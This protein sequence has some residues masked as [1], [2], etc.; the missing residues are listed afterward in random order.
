MRKV[1]LVLAGLGVAIGSAH[2]QTGDPPSLFTRQ[3]AIW[4][5]VFVIGSVGLSTADVRVARFVN[6]SAHRSEGRDRFA[7]NV[8][9]AQEGTL[10]IGNMALWGIARLA[11]LPAMAD[12][13]FHA[14]EAVVVGS[15]A[16]QVIRGPLGRS[17]PH[18]TNH[19]DQ[20]DFKP[21]RGFREFEHRAFPSIHTA[22]AFAVAT[23]YTLETQRRAPRATWIVAPVAY[24]LALGPALSRMYTG[25]HWASDILGG[26]IMGAFAGVK[27]VRYNH[28]VRPNNRVNRFF[29]GARNVQIG[30]GA[31]S[32]SASYATRF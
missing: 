18:V 25:Q 8:A 2:A 12:I 27:M 15:L 9:K 3:D 19:S 10:F 28:D 13:T 23:V 11:K 5:T 24:T 21:F 6:D 20:Y 4:A 29:L 16:S 32:F 22:S 26:A 30:V 7:R 1:P 31:S 14:A 17:R